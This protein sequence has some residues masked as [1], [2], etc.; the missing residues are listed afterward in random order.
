MNIKYQISMFLKIGKEDHIDRLQKEGLVYCNSVKYFRTLEEQNIKLR[1]DTSE[2]AVTSTKIGWMKMYVDNKELPIKFNKAR[3]HTFDEAKDLEHI[4]CMY[5]ITPDLA[6]G[7]PFIDQRNIHFG[8]AGLLILDPPKFLKRVKKAI[9]MEMTFDYGPVNYYTE[10]K[11]YKNL[12]V[13]HK[14]E[15]FSYQREFRLLFHNQCPEPLN[16]SIGSIEDI[17]VKIEASKLTG[18]LLVKGEN[19]ENFKQLHKR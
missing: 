12:T 15:F 5:A 13:F 17:S 6:T 19:L 8:D 1:K 14:Q 9:R 2:G 16:I 7:E 10:D 4:Y 18:L 11:D 3:L